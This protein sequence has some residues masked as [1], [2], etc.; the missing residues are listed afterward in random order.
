ML[1][2]KSKDYLVLAAF[3]ET[4]QT[5]VPIDAFACDTVEGADQYMLDN[6]ARYAKAYPHAVHFTLHVSLGRY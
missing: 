6:E 2:Y 1:N 5:L 4:I 3:G